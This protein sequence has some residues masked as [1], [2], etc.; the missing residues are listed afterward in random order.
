MKIYA[1][2]GQAYEPV[3]AALLLSYQEARNG[4]LLMEG[5][6]EAGA[7]ASMTAAGTAYATWGQPMI[8]F[9]IFYSMFGFQRVGDLVWSFGDQ[10]GRGFMLGATAG[11]TTLQG[12]GL[13]HCDGHSPMLASVVPN[14]RVYDPAFAY[15]LAVIIRDG[16]ERMYG[17]EPEDC[18]YYLT[19]YN[20]NLSMPA[21]PEGVEEGI[22]RG[23]YRYRAA[24]SP[25]GHR[26]QILGSGTAMLAALAAQDLLASDFGVAADVWS[27]TSYK[28]LRE[29]ALGVERWN[30]LH[31]E[32]T[33]RVPF[34]VE[35]L[36]SV[37][38]PVV[39]VTD[40]VKAV[41]DQIGR[42]VRGTFVP[43]GTDGY[44]LSDTRPSLRA[45]FEVDAHHV[46]IAV[47]HGLA[48]HGAINPAVV[49]SAIARFA[50]DAERPDPRD[51]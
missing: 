2:F 18:F 8:P 41:A 35:Q 13:Q 12:E 48:A 17:P 43:L 39:A 11:R 44:G 38:G 47:L 30:R 36:G 1:P 37:P 32:E 33:P 21:M 25:G 9:F 40:Y 4:R 24:P 16:L 50:V 20:E 28:A 46:V 45:H 7:M 3:D 15:E 19:L 23:L 42:F 34:V 26:A 5:I 22:V 6:T 51:A 49:T 27:A 10:R 14:C 31:P 29:D